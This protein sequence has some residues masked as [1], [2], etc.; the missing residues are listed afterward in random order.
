MGCQTRRPRLQLWLPSAALWLLGSPALGVTISLSASPQ[1]VPADGASQVTVTAQ[2]RDGNGPADAG[3]VVFTAS[4]STLQEVGGG[5]PA[6]RTI[7][8][9]IE[10]GVA[11]CILTA[12]AFPTEIQ[13][14]ATVTGLSEQKT[15]RLAVLIGQEPEER[16]TYENIIYVTGET[17]SYA[18]ETDL[19]IMEVLGDAEVR[20]RG[21]VIRANYIQIDLQNYSLLARGLAT[22]V[23]IALG[24]PP[25]D[26]AALADS[27]KPPYAGDLLGVG[28]LDLYGVCYS[29]LRGEAIIFQGQ[30]LT[31]Q[32]DIDIDLGMFQP[33]DLSEVRIWVQ[34]KRATIYPHD[35]IRFDRARFMVDGVKVLSQPYYFEWL[36]YN[37]SAGPAITQVINY[38][39]QDGLIVDFPYYFDVGDLY[40]NEF[41]LTRGVSTGLFGRSSGF[42]LSYAHRA[43]LPRNRGQYEFVIDEIGHTFGVHYN[44][45]QQFGPYTFGTMSLSWP[46]HRN[47]YS[48]ATLYTP[49]GP[50][51]LS[52]SLNLDYLTGFAAGLSTN[53]NLVW[54]S[55][56]IP[57][58][59]G[60]TRFSTSLGASYG[61]STLGSDRW[62]Q[63]VSLN[64]S[65]RPWYFLGQTGR[66]SPYMALRFSNT[67]NGDQ[68]LA[69]TFNTTYYQ[70]LGPYM[71]A[72]LGYTFDTTWNSR[73]V[74]PDRHLLSLNW[75]LY[76]QDRWS[77]YAFCN[78]N[79]A[80]TS[81]SASLLLDYML[82]GHWGVLG[83]TVYQSSAAGSFGETE[84]WLYRVIGARELRLRY[85]VE[86]GRLFFEIDN[87]F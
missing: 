48:N 72:S 67:I 6:G 71:S 37:A 27:S 43:D 79:L 59:L 12:T 82:T 7:S 45:Q 66:L 15:D 81:L 17:V 51:S 36:G 13:I 38:S 65:K 30:R 84:F 33:Y 9:R 21:V 16:R 20:F 77:G 34:A 60:G 46:Q 47:F 75:M 54:Q 3:Q 58:G 24:E 4:D 83:Q 25:Y 53:S 2:V 57:V 68:E 31:R 50:G 85:S 19:Q 63:T 42:Q 11:R 10:N 14:L 18:P 80:D 23:T 40:T 74:I 35:R 49:A 86:T 22:G 8:V 70:Q 87:R 56:S 39:T 41:R 29:P 55:H 44:R 1:N 62:R 61:R 64:F 69:Y 52:A 26:A 5:G 73:F 28:L 32:P 78:Y 76:Q